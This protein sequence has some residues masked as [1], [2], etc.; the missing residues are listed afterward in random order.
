MAR[1]ITENDVHEAVDALVEAGERPTVER[2]RAHLG[3]GSPN[4][5]TRYLESW[6][7]GLGRRLAAQRQ[8]VSLPAAPFAIADLAAQVW[9]AALRS[10]RAEANEALDA[11]RSALAAERA[12]F[13]DEA[14]GLV[15][16]RQHALTEADEARTARQRVEQRLSD[17]TVLLSELQD[18][19][20]DL[21]N[22]RDV[23]QGQVRQ[24]LDE[25]AQQR[26]QADERETVLNGE[27]QQHAEHVWATED[28]A[29]AEVDRARQETRAVQKQ[30]DAQL[31]ER[32]VLAAR[33]AQRE[34]VLTETLAAAQRE[35]AVAKAQLEAYR[36]STTKPARRK[37]V[38]K[39]RAPTKRA[40]S[41]RSR[42]A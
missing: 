28:R 13:H 18:R 40:S 32:D 24:L 33:V 7:G 6:W 11:E 42:P 5:V 30:L 1:G 22:Q 8:A 12:A 36:T 3:T 16:E 15:N 31:R 34:Q 2:I 4:T 39:P 35:A 23:A 38:A 17:L 37:A 10:A 20:A 19:A 14:R 29:H 9:D 25:L 21:E 26:R 41:R 27:R